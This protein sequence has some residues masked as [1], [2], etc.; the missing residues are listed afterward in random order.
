V[1]RGVDGIVFVADSSPNRQ[2]A[3]FW[4]MWEMLDDLASYGLGEA[5]VPIV[6]QFN[7]RDHAD[8]TPLEDMRRVLN[9]DGLFHEVEAVANGP[10][11]HG[12]FESL[13]ACVKRVLAKLRDA[14]T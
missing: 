11:G 1:L 6:L 14:H 13:K 12:V 7:K 9:T 8:A 2:S 4:S 10:Q 5:D 3:N